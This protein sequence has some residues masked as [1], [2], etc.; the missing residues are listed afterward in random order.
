MALGALLLAVAGSGCNTQPG[1]DLTEV[2]VVVTINNQPLPN[3]EVTLTPNDT[4]SST[5]KA[6]GVTDANG[7][8]K[9]STVG[10]PGAAVG[11]YK[12]TAID[13]PPPAEARSD[14]PDVAQR[15][16]AEY[17]A[18]LKNRPIPSKYAT[19]AQSDATVEVKKDQKEYK[20]DLKR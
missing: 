13:G 6:T 19:V 18:S 11:P 12:V 10:K 1:A 5:A 7:R 8:A 15:K 20:I 14:D 9:L 17:R 4:K 2:E 16:D 3:A